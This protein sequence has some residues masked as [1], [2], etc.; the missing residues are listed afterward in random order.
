MMDSIFKDFNSQP[1]AMVGLVNVLELMKGRISAHDVAK[2]I[3]RVVTAMALKTRGMRM[4]QNYNSEQEVKNSTSDLMMSALFCDVGYFKMEVP[5]SKTLSTNQM[6]YMKNHPILSYLMI[7]H[8]LSLGSRVKYNVLTHHRPY[9]TDNNANNYP[10]SKSLFDQLNNLHDKFSR[11]P[12]RR[13]I[14]DDIEKQMELFKRDDLYKE[15]ANIL[16]VSSEFASLTSDTEWRKAF[17][18][19]RAVQ[20]II[21][22]SYYTYPMRIVREFLDYVSLSLCNNEKIMR[23]GDY[24]I[25]SNTTASRKVFFEL[26][27]IDTIGRYQSRPYIVRIGSVDMEQ[28]SDP[29]LRL[30]GLKISSL[31]KDPRKAHYDLSNDDSK[32]IIYT[33]DP[34]YDK[35]LYHEIAAL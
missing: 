27:R 8:D 15:D 25:V 9:N 20:M 23:P 30:E 1:D 35:Q 26:C 12:E 24:I 28:Q 10:S 22:N 29:K 21:N 3:K 34:D 2:T 16:A 14:L 13:P 4:F 18:S 19:R 32:N 33:I 6:N 11:D 31:R 7:I 17:S 5:V